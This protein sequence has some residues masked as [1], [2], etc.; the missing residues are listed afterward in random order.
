MTSRF[1]KKP[2]KESA[3]ER[4]KR[5]RQA[6]AV[7]LLEAA[8]ADDDFTPQEG[9]RIGEVLKGMFGLDAAEIEEV[10]AMAE[11]DRSRSID[12]WPFARAINSEFDAREKERVIEGVWEVIYADERLDQY[13]DYLVHKIARVLHIPHDVMIRA[14]LRAKGGE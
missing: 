4:E 14:K 10:V 3:E 6:V 1:W 11:R 5:I 7:I 8:Y 2:T 9:A 12:L 13:E